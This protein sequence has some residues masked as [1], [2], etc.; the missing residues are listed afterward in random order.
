MPPL[1]KPLHS[2]QTHNP[3]C[4]LCGSCRALAALEAELSQ[5]EPGGIAAAGGTRCA[6][7]RRLLEAEAQTIATLA[8]SDAL[9]GCST[10]GA[11]PR[12]PSPAPG[13]R[14]PA[15]PCSSCSGLAEPTDSPT[16]GLAL[17]GGKSPAVLQE[18]D[19]LLGYSQGPEAGRY[20]L[21]NVAG[22]G[23]GGGEQGEPCRRG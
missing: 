17:L 2:L 18:A 1:P 11:D 14:T 21:S 19:V 22:A 5:I 12:A 16:L 8:A 6:R 7:L 9:R 3:P 4:P 15:R 13:A 23:R 20:R 10:C